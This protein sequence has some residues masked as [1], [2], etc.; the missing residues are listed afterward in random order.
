MAFLPCD[1]FSYVA[2]TTPSTSSSMTRCLGIVGTSVLGCSKFEKVGLMLGIW[3][4]WWSLPTIWRCSG[5]GWSKLEQYLLFVVESPIRVGGSVKRG[6]S[7]E[8]LHSRKWCRY[9]SLPTPKAWSLIWQF[10]RKC[11]QISANRHE[12]NK[13][14]TSISSRYHSHSLCLTYFLYIRKLRFRASK[15]DVCM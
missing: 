11:S 7:L 6:L 10:S 15:V 8:F 13:E 1:S 5:L 14:V 4:T 3:S 12:T 2:T 9:Y